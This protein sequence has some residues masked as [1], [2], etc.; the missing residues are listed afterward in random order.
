MKRKI[1]D[2]IIFPFVLLGKIIS[3]WVL[4]PDSFEVLF[5]FPFYHTGGAEKVHSLIANTFKNKKS[6]ILF[7]RK[8]TDIMIS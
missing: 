1:E 5:I 6:L 2:L 3:K 8:S 7:T 4:N